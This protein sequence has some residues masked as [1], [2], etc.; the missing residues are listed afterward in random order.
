MYQL[1]IYHDNGKQEILE[2]ESKVEL[3]RQL[4]KLNL[5]PD[6]AIWEFKWVTSKV[7][8]TEAMVKNTVMERRE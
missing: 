7:I 8:V 5:D 1:I 2:N 6:Q 3:C 4:D